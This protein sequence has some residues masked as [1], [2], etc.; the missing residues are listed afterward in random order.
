MFT[1]AAFA[2]RPPPTVRVLV[3]MKVL[4]GQP[5]TTCSA[6]LGPVLIYHANADLWTRITTQRI[7]VLLLPLEMKTAPTAALNRTRTSIYRA[8][9]IAPHF[10]GH[11]FQQIAMSGPAL[12]V[13]AAPSEMAP[14]V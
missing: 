1:A 12:I 9:T 8:D 3:P 2:L 7:A 13:R 5:L 14:R 6:I 11:Q 10:E 4:N